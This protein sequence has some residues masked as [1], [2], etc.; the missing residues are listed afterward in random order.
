MLKA[1]TARA[2]SRVLIEVAAYAGTVK[3]LTK[4]SSV[5]PGRT[6]EVNGSMSQKA[7][8]SRSSSEMMYTPTNQVIGSASKAASRAF[9]C[10]FR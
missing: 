10:R 6:R 7:V 8:T 3:R 2:I 1:V 5:N 4:L 9:G